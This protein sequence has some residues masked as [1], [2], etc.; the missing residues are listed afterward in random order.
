MAKKI[1]SEIGEIDP[2]QK[3]TAKDKRLHNKEYRKNKRDVKLKEKVGDEAAEIGIDLKNLT[4][5]PVSEPGKRRITDSI[6]QTTTSE[7]AKDLD[8][9]HDAYANPT[10]ED[11]P[12]LNEAKLA[13]QAK[14]EKR[15]KWADAL[16]ILGQGGKADPSKYVSNK[17]ER[18][19]DQQYQN[20]KTVTDKNKRAKEIFEHQYRKDLLEFINKKL[21]DEQ[22]D[23]AEKN[24]WQNA[25]DKL[26]EEI[27]QFNEKLPIEKGK[28]KL[29][30]DQLAGKMELGRGELALKDKE[31]DLRAQGK[32]GGRGSSKVPVDPVYTEL[33]EDKKSWQLTNAKNPYSDLML[34]LSGNSPELLNEFAKISG[35]AT[36]NEGNVKGNLTAGQI[37]NLSNTIVSQMFDIKESPEG[38]RI[39]SP[40]PG[41]ENYIKDISKEMTLINALKEQVEHLQSIRQE[42]IDN[43]GWFKKDDVR[44]AFDQDITSIETRIN[45]SKANLNSLLQNNKTPNK[46]PN[47]EPNKTNPDLD[48]YFE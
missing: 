33:L 34:K 30:E 45:D 31:L 47:K 37:E 3:I 9:F 39:A 10:F 12:E 26:G 14:K 38:V 48:A 27:R 7:I 25:A 19:R 24:K 8:R 5:V 40:K 23:Q 43:A 11:Q 46:E 44:D 42:S 29:G 32:I 15:A 16:Y 13:Q 4:K 6:K 22:L 18:E 20:Y 21:K 28:L 36:D 2:N 35:Y 41:M 17:L 1:N